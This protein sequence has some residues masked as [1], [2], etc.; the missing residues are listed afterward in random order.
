MNRRAMNYNSFQRDDKLRDR[1]GTFKKSFKKTF[2][3]IAVVDQ[4]YYQQEDGKS[5]LKLGN[6]LFMSLELI[7]LKFF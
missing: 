1:F 6:F 7:Q 3:S 5:F 4:K 2:H